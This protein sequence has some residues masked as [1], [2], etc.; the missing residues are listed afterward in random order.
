MSNE[1]SLLTYVGLG[2]VVGCCLAVE[3]LGGAAILSGVAGVL[4][5]S[6]GSTYLAVVGVTGLFTTLLA[7]GYRQ[8]RGVSHA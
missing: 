2:G 3:L 6:T 7:L 1:K 4:G 5:F 8:Y